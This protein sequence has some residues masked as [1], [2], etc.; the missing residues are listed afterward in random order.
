MPGQGQS[1]E[2]TELKFFLEVLPGLGY[3]QAS[4]MLLTL[5]LTAAVGV[6]AAPP[7]E[8][9]AAFYRAANRAA[10]T[11]AESYFTPEALKKIQGFRKFCDSETAGRTLERFEILKEEVKGDIAEVRVELYYA[12]EGLALHL[13][14]LQRRDGVWRISAVG[15]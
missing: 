13:A 12:N 7:A 6:K 11:E 9:F 15:A 4:R 10:Y 8:T 5:L 1:T 2:K 3:P 14:R